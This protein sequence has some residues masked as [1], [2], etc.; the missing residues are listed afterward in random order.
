[1]GELRKIQRNKEAHAAGALHRKGKYFR[2]KR[3]LRIIAEEKKRQE[4]I[5]KS[6]DDIKK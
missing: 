3:V 4:E 6:F 5:E 2:Q 1:M